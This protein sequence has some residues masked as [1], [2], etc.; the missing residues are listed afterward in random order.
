MPKLFP[1]SG[2]VYVDGKP[3]DSGSVSFRPD[4]E[5]GNAYGFEPIGEISADGTYRLMTVKG[6]GAPAGWYKVVV[7]YDKP[8]KSMYEVAVSLLPPK[9]GSAETTPLA[10]EVTKQPPDG[11]YDLKLETK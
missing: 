5:K 9:Y 8:Y 7:R 1:V 6:V 2:K 3:I 10:V 4:A 11:A